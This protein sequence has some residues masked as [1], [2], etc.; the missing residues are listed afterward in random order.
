MDPLLLPPWATRLVASG[1]L[2]EARLVELAGTAREQGRQLDALLVDAGVLPEETVCLGRAVDL[3]V[4]Y[5]DPR[6][7]DIDLAN[8]GLV[9][10][11]L[12]RSHQLFPLFA[13]GDMLTLGMRDPGDLAVVDQVRNLSYRPFR[14]GDQRPMKHTMCMLPILLTSTVAMAAAPEHP[15]PVQHPRAGQGGAREPRGR[16]PRHRGGADPR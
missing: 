13:L 10:E 8:A 5:V 12:A 4:P 16:E 7:Y 3:A 15:A 6:D 11:S 1:D 14:S 9:P 2:D